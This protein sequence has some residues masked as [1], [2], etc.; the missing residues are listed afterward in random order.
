MPETL[1]DLQDFFRG[2]VKADFEN[3]TLRQKEQR[4]YAGDCKCRL[5]TWFCEKVFNLLLSSNRSLESEPERKERARTYSAKV[6]SDLRA[7]FFVLFVF[8]SPEDLETALKRFQEQVLDVNSGLNDDELPLAE[9]P[10]KRIFGE[11][12]GKKFFSHQYELLPN[13]LQKGEFRQT[14]PLSKIL[15]W[16]DKRDEHDFFLGR[17]SFGTVYKV[18][19]AR[20]HFIFK[21]PRSRNADVSTE[22][23]TNPGHTMLT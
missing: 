17:G 22:L 10:A 23:S 4:F 7:I 19:I 12:A 5:S 18:K 8:T 16:Y 20:G 2:V 15:P 1:E 13:T 21:D 6:Y 11:S 14:F 3:G 9:E